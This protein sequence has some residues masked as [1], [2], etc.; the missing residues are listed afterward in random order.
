MSS[1][2]MIQCYYCG[3]VCSG[4]NR[5]IDHVIPLSL[6]GTNDPWNLVVACAE[7]NLRKNAKPVNEFSAQQ[8]MEFV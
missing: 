2:R 7:C 8:I 6:G 4:A 3:R 1:D 5:H